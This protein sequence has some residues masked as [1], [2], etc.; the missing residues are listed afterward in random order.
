MNTN[1]SG[2]DLVLYLGFSHPVRMPI[3]VGLQAKVEESTRVVV[4][5]YDKC[6]IGEF[7]AKIRRWRP[8]KP[9]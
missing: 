5:G 6:S 3:P 1:R 4:S 2:K 9:Y 8:S 7:A